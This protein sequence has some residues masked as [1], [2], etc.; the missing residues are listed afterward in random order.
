MQ[1]THDGQRRIVGRVAGLDVCSGNTFAGRVAGSLLRTVGLP[2]LITE[3]LGEYE[4]AALDLARNPERLAALRQK[5][6]TNRDTSA[7]F[8]VPKLTG[9]IEAAY[10][11]MWQ[12]YLARKAPE[13]FSIENA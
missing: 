3:S 13:P 4:Q 11:R 9:N 1:C 6:K 7:L 12:T 5:L 2:E 10:A 8:D